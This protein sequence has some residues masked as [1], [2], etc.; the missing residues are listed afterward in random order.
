VSTPPNVDMGSQCRRT[1]CPLRRGLPTR[2]L[3]EGHLARTAGWTTVAAGIIAN[4]VRNATVGLR[5]GADPGATSVTA[6]DLGSFELATD[7]RVRLL[8]WHRLLIATCALALANLVV[9]ALLTAVLPESGQFIIDA[10]L[11]PLRALRAGVY[12]TYFLTS[13]VVLLVDFIALGPRR[14]ALGVICGGS[15]SA[16]IDTLFGIGAAIGLLWAVVV[17]FSAGVYPVVVVEVVRALRPLVLTPH[18]PAAVH[19]LLYLVALDFLSYWHHRWCHASR[20]LWRYHSFHH[21]STTFVVLT[22][23]RVHPLEIV[24]RQFVTLV[25]LLVLGSPLA[26]PLIVTTVYRVVDQF[27]HSMV[28][29]TF[30]WVGRWIVFSP[31]GHRIHHSPLPEQW[32]ANYGNIFTIWDRLFGTWYAGDVVNERVGLDAAD[33]GSRTFDIEPTR[34]ASASPAARS[35]IRRHS[36]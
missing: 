9:A 34:S 25:P 20:W 14:S 33:R 1:Y 19:T 3:R 30:G 32:D 4:R 29:W 28:P 6:A 35:T 26:I 11:G 10:W 15:R 2:A 36:A 5:G 17:A 27:Q 21:S 8:G 16:A 12:N 22:G 24:T 23:N 13:A 18:M 31:I 7:G